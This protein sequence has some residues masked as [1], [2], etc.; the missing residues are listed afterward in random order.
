MVDCKR[1]VYKKGLLSPDLVQ[2]R[3]L[4]LKSSASPPLLQSEDIR[5]DPE[6]YEPCKNDI[7][8]LCPNVAFGNAQVTGR[9]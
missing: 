9:Q 2:G 4:S 1:D 5:L 3:A 8:R 6:L 7:S